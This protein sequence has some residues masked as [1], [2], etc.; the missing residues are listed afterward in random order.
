MRL[1][2]P[3]NSKE[4]DGHQQVLLLAINVIQVQKNSQQLR[5]R[6]EKT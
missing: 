3:K 6:Q 1:C 2:R 5:L 4:G